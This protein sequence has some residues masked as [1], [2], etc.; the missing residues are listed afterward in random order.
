LSCR[1]E[2]PWISSRERDRSMNKNNAAR[3]DRSCV[4]ISPTRCEAA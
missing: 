2:N 1:E 3:P 4:L